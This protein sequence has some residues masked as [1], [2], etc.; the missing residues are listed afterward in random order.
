MSIIKYNRKRAHQRI[1]KALNHIGFLNSNGVSLQNRTVL[2][3]GTGG[4]GI[5]IIMFSLTGAKKIYTFDV[6]AQLNLQKLAISAESFFE[7]SEKISE[8][9]GHLLVGEIG[10]MFEKVISSDSLNSALESLGCE[11][12]I[13]ENA[14]PFKS[15]WNPVMVDFFYSESNLQR[16]PVIDLKQ[17]V[18]G[19]ANLM[20]ENGISLHQ[21]DC[22]DIVAQ[23][24]F[25]TV[26]RNLSPFNFLIFDEAEW[27]KMSPR[28]QGTQNRLREFDFYDIFQRNGFH[29]IIVESYATKGNAEELGTMGVCEKF[30]RHGGLEASIRRS[31]M[32][33]SKKISDF[34]VRRF[35]YTENAMDGI[36]YRY[37]NTELGILN[38]K[39]IILGRDEMI[40]ENNSKFPII[41]EADDIGI[42]EKT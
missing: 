11:R 22:S 1:N 14:N 26:D 39:A 33:M 24:D 19:V 7:H 23:K 36:P 16:I 8:V 13:S 29:P 3:T 20:P 9:L 21:I 12:Y 25:R 27:E 40:F 42:M 17:I 38:P 4:H 35:Y 32:L 31:R 28:E 34:S 2:E 15:E 37:F 18:E 30:L 5:D 6:M 41:T 10:P